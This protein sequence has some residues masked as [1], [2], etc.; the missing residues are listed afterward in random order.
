MKRDGRRGKEATDWL[1]WED[2]H[3][4]SGAGWDQARGVG[5]ML[6]VPGEECGCGAKRLVFVLPLLLPPLRARR[7]RKDK[8]LNRC[9]EGAAA[10]RKRRSVL[11]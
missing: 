4:L 10:T 2:L 7:R 6:R 9:Q 8:K 5:V 11:H 1:L 3:L